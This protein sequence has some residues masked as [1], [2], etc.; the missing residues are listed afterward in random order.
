MVSL[1]R[2]LLLW[3]LLPQL[4]LWAAGGIA[5]YRRR[6]PQDQLRQQQPEEQFALQRDH[7]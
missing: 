3:L 2:K 6:R 7:R 4:I 5:T 1:Q